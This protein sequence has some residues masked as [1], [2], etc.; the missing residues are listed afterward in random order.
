MVKK[1][2]NQDWKVLNQ[3]NPVTTVD[4]L[5]L[6]EPQNILGGKQKSRDWV[7]EILK[8]KSEFLYLS[9]YDGR[10]EVKNRQILRTWSNADSES[11]NGYWPLLPSSQHCCIATTI[12]SADEKSIEGS[13]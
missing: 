6:Y 10:I 4:P 12:E 5:H 8:I 13:M 3:K 9:L 7:L 1:S 2:Q 11:T